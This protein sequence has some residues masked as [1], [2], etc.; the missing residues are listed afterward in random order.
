M[1]G[2]SLGG[3]IK[4]RDH[5]VR[6]F[7]DKMNFLASEISNS[8]N[9]V[10]TQGFNTYNQTGVNLFDPI[11]EKD[12]AENMKVNALVMSDVGNIAAGLDPNAPGDNRVANLISDIQ[13]EKKF[14]D[15]T[16]SLDEYYNGIVAEMGLR[17]EKAN[18]Q[19]ETQQG[20]VT[21]LENLRE[22]YSGVN[23]DQE[24]ANMVEWQKQFD[25]SARIIRTADEMLDTNG[26]VRPVWKT[27]L[28]ALSRM[29]ERELHERFARTDRY[30]RDAG[31]FYR[32]YGKGSSERNWPISHIPVLIDDREWAVLSEGLKQRA[33]LLEAMV[34]DFY[35]ENR[36]VKE[37]FVPPALIASNPE[38]LRPMVG[39]K[40]ASG[41]YLHFC[42][43]EIGRGPDGNWWVLADRTQAPSGA[44]FALENRV[45]TTRA[46]SDIYAET[47]VHRLASFFGA[48]RDTLQ[49]QR[50]HP[51]DRIAVL[52]PGPANETYFEHAYIAR[53]LGFM[54]LEGEDLTVVNGRVMVRTVAGLKPV[55][56]LWRRLDASYSDP[57][58]LNQQSHIGTPGMVQ[59][60][61]N[62]ALTVVNA[63]GSGILETRA[64]LAFMPRICRHIL[65]E[66]LKLPSIATWWCGQDAER[67]HVLEH[68]DELMVGP[69]FST[70]L[71]I[72]D[73]EGTALG[74]DI[75]RG[76][77]ARLIE[78]MRPPPGGLHNEK[79]AAAG[80]PAARRQR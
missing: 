26:K 65:G 63:L 32:D 74:R 77:R 4:V 59:A 49:A 12:G 19:L 30:L 35:G 17:T 52:T 5:D 9:D 2:G 31:V 13:H 25:A 75:G 10:H 68:F 21:Q 18:H 15:G 16:T 24:V 22:S 38:Y 47:H 60:L 34:A 42:S 11:S 46:L 76:G 1:T 20:V 43:F 3:L 66:E 40:P 55:G 33:N 41:H 69:A 57:L 56:V 62:E 58:E 79:I 27:L 67:R 54:L 78:A 61:R 36:L 45:A 14:V 44:G 53:Y 70:G 37:G 80:E 6:E 39:V 7:Q 8:V 71:A 51:D 73:P 50:K 48:F 64:L 28:D 29:S 23:I 72:D